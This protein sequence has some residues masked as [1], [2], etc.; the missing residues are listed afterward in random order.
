MALGNLPSEWGSSRIADEADLLNGR[1]SG[2]GGSWLRVFKTRHIYDGPL[3]QDSECY[4]PDDRAASIP[5]ELYLQ[6]GDTL[7]PN[8]A[9]GTI[10]RVAYVKSVGQNWTI[11][12]QVTILRSRD[13]DRLEPRFLYDWISTPRVKAALVAMEK[14]GSFGG[15]RGQTHLYRSDV[16]TIDILL[17]PIREQR[18]IAAILSSVDENIE[19]AQAVIDQVQVV[20]KS[21]IQEL[22]TKGMPGRHKA[23]K[24]TAVGR[25]PASWGV[26]RV[27]EVMERVRR[28]VTVEPT[29]RYREIG[30][31][32][33]GRGV[34]HK[35]P[36]L[37]KELGDK[38]VFWA[39]P[40]TMVINIV[41]AWE[42]AVAEI[43]ASEQGMIASHRFPMYLPGERL[44]VTFSTLY[45]Q[46]SA[47]NHALIGI[48]PGG[49]GRNKTM[50]QSDFLKLSIPL[51]PREEQDLIVSTY[52]A[53]VIREARDTAALAALK[54]VKSA[55][56]TLLLTGEL[57]VRPDPEPTP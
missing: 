56:S 36:V 22:L 25:I 29:E 27:G 52:D 18:K 24:E 21:L 4:V 26:V 7:T 55:L 34:F 14:G 11:D 28:A 10:G 2:T 6:D 8:M 51:P 32:S 23:F 54:Q 49:A 15:K 40:G 9:H 47:G 41:F 1:A 48:S 42:R 44:N 57:R 53:I 46:S 45:F 33:H 3:R 37:G 50:S 30:I 13:R 5:R 16:G 38:S 12:G 31:R 17:P 39:T 43:R 20:K 19:K 35:E